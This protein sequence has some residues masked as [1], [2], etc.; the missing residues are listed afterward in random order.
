M[1]ALLRHQVE[2]QIGQPRCNSM[3]I[4]D[5]ERFSKIAA[6]VQS[7]IISLAVAIGGLWTFYTFR[8]LRSVEK[9]KAELEEATFKRAILDIEVNSTLLNGKRARQKS[10]SGNLIPFL[11]DIVVTISNRGNTHDVL[12]MSEDSLFVKQMLSGSRGTVVAREAGSFRLLSAERNG[13]RIIIRP[14]NKIQ[15]HYLLD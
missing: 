14:G 6:G 2:Y 15:L 5:H 9:A 8:S 11:V 7:I 4:K 12:D 13:G 1:W 3:M 10:K